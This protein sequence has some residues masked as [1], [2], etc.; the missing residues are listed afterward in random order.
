M[1]VDNER[2]RALR[3][4][5]RTCCRILLWG[6]GGH[7]RPFGQSRIPTHPSRQSYNSRDPGGGHSF[8]VASRP[9]KNGGPVVGRP[10]PSRSLTTSS[11]N[12]VEIVVMSTEEE[13]PTVQKVPGSP[14]NNAQSPSSSIETLEDL[15]AR[16]RKE[17]R[18]LTATITALKKTATKGDKKKKKEVTMEVAVLED[19]LKQRHAKEEAECAKHWSE[20]A[21][22]IQDSLDDV[23]VLTNRVDQLSAGKK[24]NRQALRR[25]RK[26]AELAEMRK[27]AELEASGMVDM[28]QV[29]ID[30]LVAK[31]TPLGLRIKNVAADGHWYDLLFVVLTLSLACTM[32]FPIRWMETSHSKSFDGLLHLTLKL[33]LKNS[34]HS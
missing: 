30:A 5:N 2:A 32:R 15:H 18:E 14:E 19:E 3:R 22:S 10:P 16:H 9:M 21:S 1:P 24:P 6:H 17:Q 11:R 8:V 31:V 25:E 13:D 20:A 23:E 28:R 4:Y 7:V 29:E 27:Q 12:R 34:F 26:A 33:M